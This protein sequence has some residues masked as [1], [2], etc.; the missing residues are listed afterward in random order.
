LVSDISIFGAIGY[1]M[2][3]NENY[4]FVASCNRLASIFNKIITSYGIEQ[5]LWFLLWCL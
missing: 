5:T 1:K 3:R 2:R 4:T